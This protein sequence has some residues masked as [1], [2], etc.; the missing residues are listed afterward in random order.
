MK[1]IHQRDIISTILKRWLEQYKDYKGDEK[2][3][4]GGTYREITNNIEKLDLETCSV[5]DVKAAMGHD[6]WTSN[7]C[8]ECYKDSPVV[9]QLDEN[10]DSEASW[11]NMC[12]KCLKKAVAMLEA[13]KPKP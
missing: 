5:K 6:N 7:Q 12:L 11:R 13:T 2:F 9:L 8:D 3:P 10:P 4:S 1:P